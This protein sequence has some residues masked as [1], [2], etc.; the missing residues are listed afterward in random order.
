MC[1]GQLQQVVEALVPGLEGAQLAS[2]LAQ[3]HGYGV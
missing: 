2:V 3:P 1:S